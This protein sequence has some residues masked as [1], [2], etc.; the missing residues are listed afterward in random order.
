M[1]DLETFL[2]YLRRNVVVFHDT[3]PNSCCWSGPR[4]AVEQLS[5][6]IDQAGTPLF[7]MWTNCR[8]RIHT[9]LPYAGN[10]QTVLPS[11]REAAWDTC[12]MYGSCPEQLNLSNLRNSKAK[13]P[14]T[15]NALG[16]I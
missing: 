8:L 15:D 12:A 2:P 3:Y 1:R 5:G 13:D 14:A 16:D 4:Y 10:W 11:G 6:A 9:A 7:K